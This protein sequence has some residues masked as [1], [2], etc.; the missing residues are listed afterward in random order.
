[1]LRSS[2]NQ[3]LLRRSPDNGARP[4][5]LKTFTLL[6]LVIALTPLIQSG[7]FNAHASGQANVA[8][9]DNAFLPKH[10]NVTTGTTVIWDYASNWSSLHTV[11]SVG[12]TT[13][14]GTPLLNSGT[15]HPGQSYSYTF[16][17][18]GVYTY[19]CS[20]HFTTPAMSNAWVNV[21]G[22]PITPPLTQNPPPNYTL[23]TVAAITVAAVIVAT[24]ALF[25]R[26]KKR[27]TSV[28]PTSRQNAKP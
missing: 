26:K 9:I 20:Y 23:I 14:G 11:T 22:A 10:I 18:P 4:L 27:R 19:Q 15:L 12:N 13:Q 16:Y 7:S 8:I 28:A 24:L 2:P 1:M 17:Q 3:K 5:F 6:T 25:V 21:T